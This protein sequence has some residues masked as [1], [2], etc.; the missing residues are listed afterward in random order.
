M[1]TIV[2]GHHRPL[3]KRETLR[4]QKIRKVGDAGRL[5]NG[6]VAID[7]NVA[8]RAIKPVVIGRKNWMFAGSNAGGEILADAMTLV[9]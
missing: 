8:E 7:N 2:S 3:S 5:H 6:R 9:R 1:S 4:C